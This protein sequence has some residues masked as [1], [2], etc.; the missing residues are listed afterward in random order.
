VF[1][2]DGLKTGGGGGG[3]GFT[4]C[5]CAGSIA[6]PERVTHPATKKIASV[7]RANLVVRIAVSFKPNFPLSLLPH[8]HGVVLHNAPRRL[9]VDRPGREAA[10][11][12]R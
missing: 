2:V 10:V 11:T 4:V 8:R 5:A 6:A 3:T 9:D 1:G 7:I 12:C